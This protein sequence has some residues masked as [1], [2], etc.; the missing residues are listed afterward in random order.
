VRVFAVPP[1]AAI[2]NDVWVE[3]LIVP[4]DVRQ[5][6]PVRVKVRVFSRSQTPARVEMRSADRVLAIQFAALSSGENELA[7]QVRFPVAGTTPSPSWCPR[8]VT[9]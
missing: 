1:A 5:Q 2:S 9:R 3:T 7:L 8:K 4:D 6:E